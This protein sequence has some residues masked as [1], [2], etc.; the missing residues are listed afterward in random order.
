MLSHGAT[1]FDW[2]VELGKGEKVGLEG[3]CAG[4]GIELQ[5]QASPSETPLMAVRDGGQIGARPFMSTFQRRG[6][7]TMITLEAWVEGWERM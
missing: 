5:G 1:P 4:C 7:G 3:D 6:I 2:P